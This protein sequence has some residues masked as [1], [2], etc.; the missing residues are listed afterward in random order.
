MAAFYFLITSGGTL[1]FHGV[2]N[3][4]P[5]G[6]LRCHPQRHEV[7]VG[8]PD[9]KSEIRHEKASVVYNVKQAEW[10]FVCRGNIRFVKKGI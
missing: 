9:I 1:I 10:D 7:S 8:D 6:T 2:G 3:D 5:V 4:M